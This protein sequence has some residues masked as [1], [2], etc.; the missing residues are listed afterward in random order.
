MRAIGT[1]ASDCNAAAKRLDAA[2]S[3]SPFLAAEIH[4]DHIFN[5]EET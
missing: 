5:T 4:L 2:S 3:L 1:A